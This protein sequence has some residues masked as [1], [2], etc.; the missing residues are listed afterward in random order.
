MLRETK[1][2]LQRKTELEKKHN[3]RDQKMLHL[4]ADEQVCIY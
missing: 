3:I 2:R 1:I 4:K